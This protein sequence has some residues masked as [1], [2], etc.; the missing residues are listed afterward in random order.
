MPF[1]LKRAVAYQVEYAINQGSEAFGLSDTAIASDLDGDVQSRSYGSGYSESRS[2]G[3][4]R[5]LGTFIAPKARS[6]L[7]RLMS[8]TGRVVG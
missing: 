2:A 1:D 8:S 7:R 3:A 5:G 6:I 4:K